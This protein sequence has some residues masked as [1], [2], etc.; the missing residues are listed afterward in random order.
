MGAE[1]SLLLLGT[2]ALRCGPA[3]AAVALPQKAFVLAAA[4]Q[5]SADR[6]MSRAKL[7]T[8]LYEEAAQDAALANL[9]KLLSR[10][11]ERQA[12]IGIDLIAIGRH[13]VQLTAAAPDVD[14]DLAALGALDVPQDGRGLRQLC[15]LYRGD[16]LD[17]I[18]GC[19][20]HLSTWIQGQRVRLRDRFCDLM[21]GGTQKVGGLDAEAGLRRLIEVDPYRESAWR[22]L[23]ALRAER[24]GLTEA[25]GIFE[26]MRHR[27]AAELRTPVS[28]ETAQ[29]MVALRERFE[30]S[31]TRPAEA[32]APA[33]PSKAGDGGAA[34]PKLCILM[35]VCSGADTADAQL[36]RFLVE[37][38]TLALCRLRT[39]AV[40][41][42]HT[43]WQLTAEGVAA[44]ALDVQYLA[45]TSVWTG[46]GPARLIVKLI[47]RTDRV[48]LWAETY[49]LVTGALTDNHQHM[50]AAIALALADG[51]E[52][53]ELSRFDATWPPDAYRL[54]LLGRR[55]LRALRLQDVRR[56]R[57][58][59][60]KAADEAPR[61]VPAQNGIARCLILE[62]LLLA[63]T[64]RSLLRQAHGIATRAVAM[65]PF[66]GDARR[67]LASATLFLG[68]LDGAA[69]G[70]ARAE[71]LAPHHADILADHANA[72][73]H[74]SE[75]EL[76]V[77][78]IRKA[79]DLNP[80][81][82]DD[83][84][85]TA[86]GALFLMEDYE[87]ALAYLTRMKQKEPANRLMAACLAM[88]G[89]RDD[90]AVY[91]R[92]ALQNQP[93][94]RIADWIATIPLRSYKHVEH[95]SHALS[96]AGFS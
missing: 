95:Y 83:Y 92:R 59:F 44:D 32:K 9:R 74:C 93:N 52:R 64:D 76:A 15:E 71:Q 2:P 46:S 66:S 94:F 43:S 39:I 78:R 72:L 51:I 87:N 7:A 41:A 73:T 24:Q 77:Q 48:I 85:W 47:R 45:E 40:I 68:G 25:D 53:A 80:L 11:Q 3:G 70:F 65:D 61:F 84:L 36:S 20:E 19:G 69:D 21:Q 88:A 54:Y 14:C 63:R 10:I 49:D 89:R 8:L 12:A 33:A 96:K 31:P 23:V 17:G 34:V 30:P 6:R 50:A 58:F 13:D 22:S 35:P 42:P 38:V 86:G 26:E 4:L 27:F 81:P 16:L 57:K 1:T 29:F 62:W 28:R 91:V 82:P 67:E 90:A 79:I 75:I 56:A 60:A 18:E 37:D 55:E 5:L